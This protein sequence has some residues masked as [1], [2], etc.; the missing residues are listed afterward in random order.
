MK[1]KLFFI[2]VIAQVLLCSC[3][4]E[5]SPYY[6]ERLERPVY[7]SSGIV[8]KIDNSFFI[9]D[10]SQEL[11]LVGAKMDPYID[12]RVEVLGE[13]YSGKYKGANIRIINVKQV[14]FAVGGIE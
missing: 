6:A 12:R 4:V 13:L 3:V 8:K 5:M 7:T 10:S 1:L 11:L 9:I 14:K 2:T